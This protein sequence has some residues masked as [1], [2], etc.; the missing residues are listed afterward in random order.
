MDDERFGRLLLTKKLKHIDDAKEKLGSK[1]NKRDLINQVE[2]ELKLS[3]GE[4]DEFSVP[5]NDEEVLQHGN[6]LAASGNYPVGTNACFNIGISGGCGIDCFEFQRGRC[7]EPE[8][9]FKYWDMTDEEISEL[10]DNGYYIKEITEY[11]KNRES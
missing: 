5:T 9:G 7:K 3:Y 8:E 10:F 6:F 11:F 1:F 2:K 4:Q